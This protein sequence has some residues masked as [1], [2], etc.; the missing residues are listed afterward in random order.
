MYSC[1]NASS[2]KNIL[3]DMRT[4]SLEQMNTELENG[5]AD[6]SVQAFL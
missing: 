6:I 4:L 5:Y 3:P 2:L 1:L